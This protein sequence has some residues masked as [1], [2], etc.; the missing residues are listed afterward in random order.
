M[1]KLRLA[2]AGKKKYPIYRVVATDMRSPRDG[3][4]IESVGQYNPNMN[5]ISLTLKEARVFHWLKKGAQP[6]NTVRSLLQRNGMWLKWTLQRRGTDEAKAQVIIEK[7]Q[8]QQAEKSQ[9]EADKKTRRAEKKKAAKAKPAE[10]APAAAPAEAPA[11][12]A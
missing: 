4:Y 5:P 9:R 10:A 6:T 3:R 7:W 11:A 12:S 1:V 2:R 8:M